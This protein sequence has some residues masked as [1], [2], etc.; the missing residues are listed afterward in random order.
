M[1]EEAS[2]VLVA[3]APGKVILFGEHAVVRGKLAIA[4]SLGL[5]T[6][7][8]LK[9]SNNCGELHD[10]AFLVLELP[11]LGLRGCWSF[12]KHLKS[13]SEHEFLKQQL[14]SGFS[15]SG[16]VSNLENF[17]KSLEELLKYVNY[18][19][20]N[21]G[22]TSEVSLLS[23]L[24][25]NIS[26]VST[27]T[28]TKL[29]NPILE[30]KDSAHVKGVLAF[31]Y[32]YLSLSKLSEQD[33]N[34]GNLILSVK[35]FLPVGM[36]LGSSAAFSVSVSAVLLRHFLRSCPD[37]FCR[38]CCSD[39]NE[40][41]TLCHA[42][43]TLINDW[44]FRAEKVIHG[45]PS[46][47]DNTV[48]SLGGTLTLIRGPTEI[49]IKQLERTP[50]LRFLLVNTK[51]PRKTADLVKKVGQLHE[52]EPERINPILEEIDSISKRCLEIFLR[53][54]DNQSE[55]IFV[56]ELE[57]LIDRNQILLCQLGVGHSSLDNVCRITSQFG[58]HSKLTGAG[59]G[60]CAITF[61]PNGT[62]KETIET[63]IDQL[64]SAGFEC[65]HA[66]LGGIGVQFHDVPL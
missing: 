48:C 12:R 60:G 31:L 17:T 11:D 43:K 41:W 34:C 32:L 36:G 26:T 44:A 1:V 6:F 20:E 28:T 52:H 39:S 19:P 45:N 24:G 3:S 56:R 16:N 8:S 22:S 9:C 57:S 37:K 47:V 40:K 33:K 63:V 35:S 46:G 38:E 59:G 54:E 25:G 15:C 53:P 51:V 65:F 42:R 10:D 55:E 58:L 21:S 27:S 23:N 61:L 13:H 7:A 66:E 49:Q 2:A 62:N 18:Q 5:R 50:S 4:T 29:S 30:D 14:Q 64:K